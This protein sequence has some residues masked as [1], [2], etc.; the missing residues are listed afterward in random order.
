MNKSEFIEKFAA[1]ADLS[2]KQAEMAYQSFISV[3][4]EAVLTEGAVQIHGLGTLKVSKRAA[5][6]GRN[7]RTGETIQVAASTT[8]KFTPTKSFKD[9][10]DT[11]S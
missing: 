3:V 1:R 8:A 5:R 10:L 4:Q 6:Q 9:Q 7:P 2:K 11:L